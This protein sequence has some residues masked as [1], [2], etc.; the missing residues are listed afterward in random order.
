LIE[1]QIFLL[2]AFCK[3]SHVLEVDVNNSVGHTVTVSGGD[4]SWEH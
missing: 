3:I 4:E 2:G 1:R